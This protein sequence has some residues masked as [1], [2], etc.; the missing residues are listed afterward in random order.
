MD[1]RI[2]VAVIVDP[3]PDSFGTYPVEW[4]DVIPTHEADAESY[5]N[6]HSSS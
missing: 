2:G 5:P 3:C 6:T 1:Q 4:I